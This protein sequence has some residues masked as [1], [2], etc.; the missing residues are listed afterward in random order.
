MTLSNISG[1]LSVFGIIAT[2]TGAITVYL[3]GK[4]VYTVRLHPLSRFPG[5]VYASLS[6]IPFWIACITGR[7]VQWMQRLHTRFGPVVRY[8]PN[9]L[10]YVDQDHAA[11]RGIHGQEKGGREFPKAREWFVAPYNGVYGINSAP[12]HQDH[13]RFRQVFAPA[14]SARALKMQEP[15]FQQNIDLLL[16]ALGEAAAAGEP[17]NMV[18]MYQFTTFDIMGHLTFGKPLGLLHNK[19]YSKWVDAV[20]DSIRAI[21]IAQVIQYFPVLNYLFKLVE[22]QSIKQ[23]KY[24][25]FK[26]SAD[27]VDERLKRGSEEADIW[28][29]VMD[30]DEDKRLSLEEMHCHGDV[31]MLAGSETTGTSLS[32]LTY[33]LLINPDKLALLVGEIRTAFPSGS[34]LDMQHVA[35]LKYLSACIKEA[36]RLYPPVPVGVPRVVPSVEAGRNLPGGPVPTGT[37]VSVHHF[38]TYHSPTNFRD[39][40]SFV[41]ERWLNDPTYNCDNRSCFRPFAIGPR[42]CLGQGMAMHEMQLLVASVLLKFNMELCEDSLQWDDQRAFVLWEKKPLMCRLTPV[43]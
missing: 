23:M 22:P 28:S 3:A 9:A 42:D 35:E 11:W 38:S 24:N 27:R 19:A 26:Y 13:R 34:D 36:L 33:Y 6:S 10:N 39:P 1:S 18:E 31:F 37:R 2:L 40:D 4:V 5:P 20:F 8:S 29:M 25:H 43:S 41:P 16:S 17:V 30:A 15:I 7:Q 21:P 14:F 12:A 32:G